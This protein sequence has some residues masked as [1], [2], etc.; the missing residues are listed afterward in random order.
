MVATGFRKIAYKALGRN[1]IKPLGDLNTRYSSDEQPE[2][3]REHVH[4]EGNGAISWT[5]ASNVIG[6]KCVK[7]KYGRRAFN[8]H[9]RR[10]WWS[11][12]GGC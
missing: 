10:C 4:L 12:S 1:Q 9:S 3:E 8:R 7:G 5:D 2:S 11:P 6:H